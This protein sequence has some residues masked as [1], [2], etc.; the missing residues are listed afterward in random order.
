ML[1]RSG[2]RKKEPQL[3]VQPQLRVA[4]GVS[5]WQTQWAPLLIV[6]GG[7]NKKTKLVEADFMAA[8]AYQL[9]LPTG[10][11]IEENRS[12]D[13]RENAVN[14][15]S[16]MNRQSWTTALVVTSNYHT[17]RACKI[18][19]KLQANVR[20]LAA[21]IRR[22]GSQTLGDRLTDFRSVV[23]E[24]GAIVYSWWRGYI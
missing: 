19:R 5:L 8:Y 2:V 10:A 24:Y 13:T 16:I 22:A 12:R 20:C 15:L 6:S 23:R 1:F 18:F 14:S 17:W 9:G 11:V 3:P 4:A 21:P 7:E